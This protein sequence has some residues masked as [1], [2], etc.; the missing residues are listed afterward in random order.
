MKRLP[1]L[2]LIMVL[3]LSSWPM[4]ANAALVDFSGGVS[5]EY[6]YQEVVFLSG[7]P[8]KFVGTVK[9]TEKSTT[10]A[11][12]NT[13]TIKYDFSLKP[14]DSK[15]TGKLA[16]K[17]DYKITYDK[18]ASKNQ[19]IAKVEMTSNKETVTVGD[20]SFKMDDCQFSKS[21]IIDNQPAS[22]YYNGTLT[23]RKYYSVNG[24]DGKL[25][26]DISGG[27]VGYQNFWGSTDT[28]ILNYYLK[29]YDGAVSTGDNFG[30]APTWEGNVKVDVSD[31][32]TKTL[33]Y[34][35]NEASYS[36]FPGGWTKVTDEGMFSRY[37]Y[38]LPVMNKGKVGTGRNRGTAELAQTMMPLVE[39]LIVPKF[40]DT[41][42]HWAEDQ[43]NQLYSLGVMDD[44]TQ[45][46][47]PDALITRKD[48]VAAVV[49]ACDIR[50]TPSTA[51]K[52]SKAK[53]AP[54][55]SPFTDLSVS[56]P[57]YQ[58]IKDAVTKGLVSGVTPTLFMPD[59]SMTRAEA[60][61]VLI[62]ALGM[63]N[64]APNPGYSLKGIFLDA[65]DIPLWAYD[66]MYVAHDIGL[67]K[68]D[69]SGRA[70][71]N[72]EMSRA[73]ASAMLISFLDFLRADLQ[74]D[75]RDDIIVY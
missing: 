17:I 30:Q 40:R 36:S 26:L 51:K 33:R 22:D 27:T 46:F 4:V 48:F 3:V 39:R 21:D 18:N 74:K 75:Y 7:E 47:A 19:T 31:S 71:P 49:K 72:Q 64:R 1:A 61:T 63:E 62:K 35:N 73:E 68:G 10:T 38:D 65:G 50:V 23:C 42:G 28:Q 67:I 58:Y 45:F 57:D 6:E 56:D 15:V 29:E 37:T 2:I 55:V 25:V 8:V 20:Q 12:T 69:S 44:Q 9:V 59:A 60:I 11:T 53:P 52:T 5:N 34:E 70:N 54:E 13:K 24:T 32:L 66:S 16:R 14:A 41:A 43:I